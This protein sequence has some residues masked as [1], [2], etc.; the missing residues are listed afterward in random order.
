MTITKTFLSASVNGKNILVGGTN[1]S[2]ATTIHTAPA[3]TG[4]L[5]E[6]WLYATNT[7]TSSYVLN[8]GN[9]T[10]LNNITSITSSG[11]GRTLVGRTIINNGTT[12]GA[13]CT[14]ANYIFV[15]DGY[16]MRYTPD[17]PLPSSSP[18]TSY[19]TTWYNKVVS[20]G[21]NASASTLNAI[22]TFITTLAVNGLLNKIYRCNLF[23]GNDITASLVPLINTNGSAVDAQ[24]KF[25]PSDYTASIGLLGDGS[26][27]YINTGLDPNSVA[28]M[29][30]NNAHLSTY[31][32]SA[33]AVVANRAQIGCDWG[34]QS[35]YFA[36]TAWFGTP[37]S[38]FFL[39]GQNAPSNWCQ[40]GSDNVTIPGYYIGTRGAANF[41]VFYKDLNQIGT[42]A[43]QSKT[44]LPPY[45]VY[46]FAQ[47]D[48]NNP[49]YYCN[50]RLGGYTIGAGLTGVEVRILNTAMTTF[51]ATRI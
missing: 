18:Y 13:W 50:N 21:S 47:N 51:Q 27:K 8:I 43:V 26:T 46:V 4:S 45:N 29:T 2:V 34:V 41:S 48:A 39:C 44:Q 31:V 11:G 5:D 12:I 9:S 49:V 32:Q 25:I 23:C 22:D 16:V 37:T 30:I 14:Q 19:T 28:G 38:S 36:I 1:Y 6:V 40:Y 42:A 33:S 24:V 15:I 35:I 20:S 17:T 7:T 10:E 3:G